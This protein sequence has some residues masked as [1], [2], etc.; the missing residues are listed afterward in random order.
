MQ[1][2]RSLINIEIPNKRVHFDFLNLASY[3]KSIFLGIDKLQIIF[4]VNVVVIRT[5]EHL[6]GPILVSDF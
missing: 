1:L 5:F 6:I 4:A 2:L 3:I